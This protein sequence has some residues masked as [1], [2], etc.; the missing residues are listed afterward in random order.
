MVVNFDNPKAPGNP[1]VAFNGIFGGINWGTNKWSW[2]PAF[3]DDPNNSISF[4]FNVNSVSFSFVTA[5][6]LISVEIT[7][8]DNCTVTLADDQAQT[9]S[10]TVANNSLQTVQTK[11]SRPSHTVT[12]GSS[13]GW[14]MALDNITYSH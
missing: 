12:V 1:Y 13:C 7:S 10:Y 9:A 11:W 8:Q 2:E 5:S 14:D 3:A 6:K 4:L